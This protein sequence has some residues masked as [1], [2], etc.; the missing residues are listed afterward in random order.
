M[1]RKSQQSSDPIDHYIQEHSLRLTAEQ[2]ELVEYT[3][4]LP[5]YYFDI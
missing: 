4:S 3:N 5:G 1:S 2:N